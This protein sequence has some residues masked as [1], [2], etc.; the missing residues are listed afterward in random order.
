MQTYEET[1]CFS[2]NDLDTEYDENN[3]AA[4]RLIVDEEEV[5]SIRVD[6]S[7]CHPVA[8]YSVDY[9]Q[10]PR[11]PKKVSLHHY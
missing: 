9:V 11:V 4:W 7:D 10:V 1:D 3:V 2:P 6:A 8:R 5:D